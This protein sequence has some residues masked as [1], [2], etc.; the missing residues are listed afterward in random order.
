M[1]KLF[2]F[3][4]TRRLTTR[5]VLASTPHEE[6]DLTFQRGNVV[7]RLRQIISLPIEKGDVVL[8][9]SWGYSALVLL[10]VKN[11]RGCRTVIRLR[12]DPYSALEQKAGRK[13]RIKRLVMGFMFRN[14]DLIVFNSNYV[15]KRREYRPLQRKSAMIYNPLM[16][17][18]TKLT[19]DAS[20]KERTSAPRFRLLSVTNFGYSDKIAPL[21]HALRYWVDKDFLEEGNIEWSIL[22]GGHHLSSLRDEFAESSLA[23][24]VKI[25][26]Y[27]RDVER[28]YRS[29]HV[30]VHLSGFD[31]LPNVVLEAAAHNLPVIAV[32][33]GGGTLEAMR[34]NE[35]GYIVS[36]KAGFQKA[37]LEYR[38]SEELRKVHGQNGC[39]LVLDNFT[40]ERQKANMATL[41]KRRFGLDAK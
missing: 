13:A 12:G 25:F 27:R 16:I 40:I 20:E 7:S 4:E 35:T 34:D 11:L 30:F 39:R 24:R 37:I 29:H 17:D 6:I 19:R 1:P 38:C 31:S 28:F 8:I 22:G 5:A 10:L 23:S 14:T 33:Q 2:Y 26:G 3:K 18:T 9:D 15:K 41:L 36:D 32:P 21:L